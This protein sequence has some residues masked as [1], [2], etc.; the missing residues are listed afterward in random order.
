M[1]GS[2]QRELGQAACV[3]ELPDLSWVESQGITRAGEPDVSQVNEELRF[4]TTPTG[5]HSQMLRGL[6][7]QAREPHVGW[8]LP[9]PPL[10][11]VSAWLLYILI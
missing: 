7:S 1:Q 2:P 5:F 11:P 8:D 6:L 3:E 4:D 10:P 9:I